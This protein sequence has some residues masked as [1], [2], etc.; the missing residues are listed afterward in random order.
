M[1]LHVAAHSDL[2]VPLPRLVGPPGS[3][4]VFVVVLLPQ[5]VFLHI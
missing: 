5:Q 1:V 2:V 3:P 4:S